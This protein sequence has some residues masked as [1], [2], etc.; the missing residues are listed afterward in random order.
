MGAARWAARHQALSPGRNRCGGNQ[1]FP[2]SIG[3]EPLSYVRNFSEYEPVDLGFAE[4]LFERTWGTMRFRI[5]TDHELR[6]SG[7]AFDFPKV[8]DLIGRDAQQAVRSK[9]TMNRGEKVF[10]YDST[11]PMPPFGPGIGKHQMKQCDRIHWQHLPN[12][13]G[14]FQPQNARVCELAFRDF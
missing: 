4:S 11:A 14:S 7:E 9:G 3:S 1:C 13:I 6:L 10:R 5:G 12:S 2:R 8:C